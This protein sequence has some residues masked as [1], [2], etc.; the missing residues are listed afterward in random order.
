MYR[1]LANLGYRILFIHALLPN[2]YQKMMNVISRYLL[3]NSLC[4]SQ[5]VCYS[6]IF[7]TLVRNKKYILHILTRTIP[8][9]LFNNE[10]LLL[11]YQD[12]LSFR[13]VPYF[14]SSFL[15]NYQKNLS[16]ILSI[17]TDRSDRE[18]NRLNVHRDLE[19][20][21]SITIV[22]SPPHKQSPAA[23]GISKSLDYFHN[24]CLA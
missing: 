20:T 24:C 5:F 14:W 2:P 17:T 1:A 11:I 6:V 9:M 23:C 13:R 7:E 18:L 3:F 12:A 10:M 16:V 8:R 19:E 15:K 4:W 21:D 22:F